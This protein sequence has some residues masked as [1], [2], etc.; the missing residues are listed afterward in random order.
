M[1]SESKRYES[2]PGLDAPAT[3]CV[4]SGVRV[5]YA[6]SRSYRNLMACLPRQNYLNWRVNP[7][8]IGVPH[9]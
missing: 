5:V 1:M 3:T 2:D 4:Y 6:L 7:N 9:R 8:L